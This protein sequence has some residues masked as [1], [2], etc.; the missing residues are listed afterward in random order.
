M[1]KILLLVSLLMTSMFANS[2]P[3]IL[4]AVQEPLR[5]HGKET[6]VFD[7]IQPDGTKG[8]TGNKGELFDVIL[9]NETSVPISIHWHGLVVPNNQD[10]I[11]YVTQL[12][13]PPGSSQHYQFKLLQA[14]TYW[15]H[16]HFKF[17]EQELMSAPLILKDTQEP[18]AGDKDVVVMFQGFSFKK[19]EE[20]FNELQHQP[21]ADMNMDMSSKPDL[22]DVTFDAYLANRRTLSDPEIVAVKPSEKI[23]LRLING[24][25]AS[26]FWI[27]TGKLKATAIAVDGNNIQ[28]IQDRRFQ[29]A[30]AQRMDLEVTIPKSG[31]AFPILAQVEGT[32]QQTGIILV[33]SGTAAPQLSEQANN[34]IPAL[35]NKQEFLFHSLQ[36]LAKKPVTKT[37]NYKLTG[38]MQ[39]YIWKIN[40]QVWPHVTPYKIKQGDRVE[41]VFTNDTG[42]AHPMH[43]H[44]HIFQVTEIKGKQLA[45]G[46]LRDTILVLPHT[47]QKIVFDA[48]N[49]GIWM[50]HCHVLYHMQA[51]M[52][53]TTNYQDYPLPDYYVDI[54]NGKIPA[55]AM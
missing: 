55:D 34:E 35:N 14:G 53:T 42:M 48:D 24:S 50:L 32:K 2:A 49:P 20:I 28:P 23:R 52:M 39:R 41:M 10:G 8:F 46:P 18:Y 17:H 15:M 44:G 43:F 27:N 19:P 45:N 7:I 1:S 36:P 12:P 40:N 4:K 33:T 11:P 5:V 13:I 26:N 31:G 6:T 38:D 30:V 37:L 21:M 51:G 29:L 25:T 9:K 16:S 54:L 3:T 47:T 22:N